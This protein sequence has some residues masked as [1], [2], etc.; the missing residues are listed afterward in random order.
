MP[1]S[2]RRTV[3]SATFLCGA[4]VLCLGA[5]ACG[6]KA[7]SPPLSEGF[8]LDDPEKAGFTILEIEGTKY[9]NADFARFVHLTLGKVEIPLSAEAAGRLFDDF[10]DRKIIA[11]QAGA[12]GLT[13]T[14]EEKSKSPGKIQTDMGRGTAGGV[15]FEPGPEDIFEELLVEKYLSSQVRDVL[16]S[17]E[18]I[19]SFYDA[20]KGDYLQPERLQVSQILLAEEGKAMEI[21]EK[22]RTAGEKEFRDIARTSSAGP[23]AA[24]GGVMGIFSLGQLPM[25][26][27][28][29]IFSLTEGRISRVVQSAYGYH[30]FR[31]DKK[32]EA[33]LRP[34]AEAAPIIKTM[35]LEAKSKET[36]D[37]HVAS[38]KKTMP[39]TVFP[40]NLPFIFKKTS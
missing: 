35:L 6:K 40:E 18:E 4:A 8:R 9:T 38:L 3:F 2:H 26:L 32:F 24:K 5:G 11:L 31:L 39:W 14:E 29:V 1:R 28:K 21:L 22:L 36:A 13:L 12:Q 16:V 25:E 34:Q 23:E 19:A 15:Q 33:R 17:D 20:H 37:A 10:T 27:E 30:I 7:A